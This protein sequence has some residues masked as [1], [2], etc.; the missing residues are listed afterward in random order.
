[1]SIPDAVREQTQP[2]A[3]HG[4]WMI[5]G[6]ERGKLF[7]KATGMGVDALRD[8]LADNECAYVLLA[9]RLTLQEIPDQLRQ[10]FI[11]WKGP[12]ASGMAK[13]KANQL[14]Q[15]ALDTLSVCLLQTRTH[16]RWF[17]SCCH[18]LFHFFWVFF[19]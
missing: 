4:K 18:A 12:A 5:L 8:A 16:P 1:M 2:D 13:V 7:L 10:I 19:S 6:V 11:Q 3:P 17:S 14:F 15:E 9:L